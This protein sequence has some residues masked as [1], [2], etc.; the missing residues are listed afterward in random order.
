[1]QVLC[2]C[3]R[4]THHTHTGEKMKTVLLVLLLSFALVACDTALD[5]H[6]HDGDGE[7]DHSADEHEEEGHDEETEDEHNDS[8]EPMN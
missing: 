2:Y 8:E 5:D 6:D 7:Q 4:C 3:L 1:M